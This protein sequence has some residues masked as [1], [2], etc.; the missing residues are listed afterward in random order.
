MPQQFKSLTTL[1]MIL[2]SQPIPPY[3]TQNVTPFPNHPSFQHWL[4]NE[5]EN[6]FNVRIAPPCQ[7]AHLSHICKKYEIEDIKEHCTLHNKN[8]TVKREKSNEIRKIGN[9]RDRGGTYSLKGALISQADNINTAS[10]P[11]PH[12]PHFPSQR[13]QRLSN[14]DHAISTNPFSSQV[15]GVADLSWLRK[16]WPKYARLAHW[17]GHWSTEHLALT[18]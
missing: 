13:S 9:K 1:R 7:S 4:N 16:H 6:E 18:A 11:D 8:N 3:N 15:N 10:D 12:L 17:Q 5:N 2:P 14:A